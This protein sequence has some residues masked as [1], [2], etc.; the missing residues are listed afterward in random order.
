MDEQDA[1]LR[2]GEDD[3][4]WEAASDYVNDYDP[5]AEAEPITDEELPRPP[6]APIVSPP[7]ATK[8]KKKSKKSPEELAAERLARQEARAAETERATAAFL[9]RRLGT[10]RY[11]GGAREMRNPKKPLPPG[12]LAKIVQVIG[13]ITRLPPSALRAEGIPSTR[14]SFDRIAIYMNRHREW[15]AAAHEAYPLQSTYGPGGV[16]ERK[17]LVELINKNPHGKAYGMKE[18]LVRLQRA[19]AHTEQDCDMS[20]EVAPKRRLG[21][22]DARKPGRPKQARI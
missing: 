7:R 9:A 21:P 13:K 4:N 17:E 6:P 15:V 16:A 14:I 12:H 20:G 5:T 8:K 1:F 19:R 3:P 22:A 18:W 2:E 11:I 10:S